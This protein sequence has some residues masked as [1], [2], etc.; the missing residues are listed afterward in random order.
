VSFTFSQLTASFG[1]F[2]VDYA[3]FGGVG[4][5]TFKNG[6][7]TIYT[8]ALQPTPFTL[9]ANASEMSG[10]VGFLGYVAATTAAPFD[11]IELTFAGTGS[12][13]TGFDNLFV[14]VVGQ[15]TRV[16]ALVGQA[17]QFTDTSTN[18]PTSWLWNFGD[19]TT[20]TLQNPTKTYSTTGTRTVTLT[21]TNAGGS[22]AVTKTG[23]VVVT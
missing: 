5:W 16:K 9:P 6:A 12:D 7:S 4:T 21:A 17:I 8:E 2:L 22:N 11:R 14:G 23:Y 20:S 19:S 13:R 1:L 3:D 18:T 15:I 10:S